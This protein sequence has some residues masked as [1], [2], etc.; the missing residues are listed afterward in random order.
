MCIFIHFGSTPPPP[1]STGSVC[2]W[3]RVLQNARRRTSWWLI[4]KHQAATSAC[5]S[6]RGHSLAPFGG[7]VLELSLGTRGPARRVFN[8]AA[9]SRN[10]WKVTELR[11]PLSRRNSRRPGPSGRAPC[12]VERGTWKPGLLRRLSLWRAGN[13]GCAPFPAEGGGSAA[14]RRERCGL[15]APCGRGA[16]ALAAQLRA[17]L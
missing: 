1:P 11:T 17:R 15:W 4:Q 7:L 9:C 14:T 6:R 5:V 8:R 10:V 13:R 16:C 12:L 3:S 2:V